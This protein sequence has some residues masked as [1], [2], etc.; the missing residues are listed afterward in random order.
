MP[1]K[2]KKPVKSVSDEDIKKVKPSYESDEESVNS[3][4][5]SCDEEKKPKKESDKESDNES[6]DDKPTKKTSVKDDSDSESDDVIEE[7]PKK[8]KSPLNTTELI[9][10]LLINNEEIMK[11]TE[12]INDLNKK[13]I[14]LEKENNKLFKSL[15][16]KTIKIKSTEK[17]NT[18]IRKKKPVPNVLTSFLDL[19]D[20]VLMSRPDIIKAFTVKLKELNLKDGKYTTLNKEVVKNLELDKSYINKQLDFGGLQ[21][22]IA[23]LCAK[24]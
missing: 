1:P 19:E 8:K 5:S 10:K 17:T 24:E 4:Y 14:V 7:K 21:T 2:S 12:D 16:S 20:D 13:K 11:L 6:D 23:T 3:E 22:L 15:S 18:G 9:T